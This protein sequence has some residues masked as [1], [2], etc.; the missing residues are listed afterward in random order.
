[1]K[2]KLLSLLQAGDTIQ[3]GDLFPVA[4]KLE[5]IS[6]IHASNISPLNGEEWALREVSET[7]VI[8]GAEKESLATELR[9]RKMFVFDDLEEAANKAIKD[10]GAKTV[11]ANFDDYDMDDLAKAW[12]FPAGEK[13]SSLYKKECIDLICKISDS[14]G[15]DVI[16]E[17]IR[18]LDFMQPGP[19]LFDVSSTVNPTDK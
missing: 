11:A 9:N 17:R 10:M 1:M 3:D 5:P 6:V 4:G 2:K 13:G 12:I 16:Y 18:D 15:W 7:D 19:E 8:K 14:Q